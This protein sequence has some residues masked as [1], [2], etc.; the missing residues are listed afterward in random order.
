V[1]EPFDDFIFNHAAGCFSSHV[2]LF[3]AESGLRAIGELT[4][5]LADLDIRFVCHSTIW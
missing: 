3:L 5:N 4:E 1:G 2:T